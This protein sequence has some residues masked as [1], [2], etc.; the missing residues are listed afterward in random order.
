VIPYLRI[1]GRRGRGLRQCI[2][3]AKVRD[4]RLFRRLDVLNLLEWP[5]SR[6][7]RWTP[8]RFTS[9]EG[10]PKG[11]HPWRFGSAVRKYY[12]EVGKTRRKRPAREHCKPFCPS[13]IEITPI[14][15]SSPRL[16]DREA[17]KQLDSLLGLL[18]MS[19]PLSVVACGVLA[20]FMGCVRRSFGR[21]AVC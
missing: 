15:E 9:C 18:P 4:L 16:L 12:V 10:R 2:S 7:A 20:L 14:Y 19:G 8:P 6:A 13:G 17:N 11:V 1:D 5:P 21:F 3:S